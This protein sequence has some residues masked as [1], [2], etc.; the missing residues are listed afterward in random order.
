[1]LVVGG[2]YLLFEDSII[3]Q[4]PGTKREETRQ[5]APLISRAVI[6]I[7]VC[8]ACLSSKLYTNQ[9]TAWTHPSRDDGDKIQCRFASGQARSTF[10]HADGRM[11]YAEYAP[12]SRR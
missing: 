11:A 1:M 12:M 7:Q 4:L 6:G 3:E 2:L 8:T 10:R 5:G 9:C